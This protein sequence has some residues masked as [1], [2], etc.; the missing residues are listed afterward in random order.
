[1]CDSKSNRTCK[2]KFKVEGGK[3]N[4]TLTAWN[5]LGKV[6]IQVAA[7]LTE[8]VHMMA[9]HELTVAHVNARN[10]SLT[11]RWRVQQYSNLN[12]TC[13]INITHT[14]PYKE[15]GVG[16]N[17]TVLIN[18]RPNWKYKVKVRCGT[19]QYFWKWGDWSQSVTFHTEGDVPDA[20]DVWMKKEENQTVI[21][22]KMPLDNQSHGD[23]TEYEVTWAKI[24]DLN[25]LNKTRVHP[26]VHRYTLCVDTSGEHVVTVTARNKHGSS[27]PS[28]ITIP[29]ISPN[30][31][32]MNTSW[33]TGSNGGFNLSWFGSPIASCGYIVDWVPAVGDGPVDWQKLRPSQTSIRITSISSENLVDGLRYLLSIYACTQT[34]PVLLEKKEGYISETRIQGNLFNSLKFKWNGADV[35]IS[36][37]PVPLKQQS[38]FIRGY[39]LYCQDKSSHSFSVTSDNP[40][41]T[42]LTAK[43]LKI[44]SYTFTVVA[45]TAVGECGNTSITATLNFQTDSFIKTFFI[46]LGAVSIL[47][48]LITV[49][50]Y[51]HWS[52]IKQKVYPQIPKPDMTDWLTSSVTNVH[53]YLL[54]DSSH[55]TEEHMDIPQL[56]YKSGE[57]LNNNTHQ[58][59]M[60][61]ISSQ[62]PQGYQNL[63]LDTSN[64]NI[65]S[66]S[67]F[68]NLTYNLPMLGEDRTP[69]SELKLQVK[70]EYQPQSLAEIFRQN[71]MDQDPISFVSEYI[72][73][74]QPRSSQ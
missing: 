60:A 25:Q 29:V 63:H 20:L 61:L 65:P 6:E 28:N 8:R 4:W 48:L 42:S 73:T 39:V 47:L 62:T 64:P 30:K 13:Q 46:S 58:K 45:R 9:P 40:E 16:L 44:S 12:L 21:V 5:K 37:D 53:P 32:S 57:P 41:D 69:T 24:G 7:D 50:C 3:K 31:T 51:R 22:W 68:S 54:K 34:S 71:Q 35:E 36:W 55:H 2:K 17:A 14:Q 10:A 19:A 38:A 56:L 1:T 52:C 70:N 59:Q 66:L 74:P 11:W 33:I 72:M 26:S 49:L 67:V 43:N 23:I 18:L 27:P 15:H